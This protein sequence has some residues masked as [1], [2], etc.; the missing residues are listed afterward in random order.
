MSEST[1]TGIAT[2]EAQARADLAVNG[3]EEVIR[4]AHADV[5]ATTARTLREEEAARKGAVETRANSPEVYDLNNTAQFEI[6]GGFRNYDEYTDENI[7][8]PVSATDGKLNEILHNSKKWGETE[9]IRKDN[10]EDY[11]YEVMDL[12]DSGLELCQAKM[13]QD[14][15]ERDDFHASGHLIGSFISEG[16]EPNE[17][18]EKA[19]E[20]Y[21]KKDAARIKLIRENGLFTMQEYEDFRAQRTGADFHLAETAAALEPNPAI[22][23]P[24]PEVRPTEATLTAPDT[25]VT[26]PGSVLKNPGT[27][28]EDSTET[29]DGRRRRLR[30]EFAVGNAAIKLAE[31]YHGSL[32]SATAQAEYEAAK[33]R[34]V[35]GNDTY[36]EPGFDYPGFEAGRFDKLLK[37]IKR[38]Y[39]TR[40]TAPTPVSPALVAE[41]E[42]LGRQPREAESNETT[43]PITAERRPAL[44][45]RF[46]RRLKPS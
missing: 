19:D 42:A 38:N 32:P 43:A 16:L 3:A 28:A 22:S 21:A 23:P 6:Y 7:A 9:A 26:D 18:A 27:P 13:V 2:M 14:L 44:I 31:A 29:R 41:W 4:A 8:E 40:N 17:A 20:T 12:V 33:D 5:A 15:R 34:L 39:E 36:R 1:P 25:A 45:K 24:T 11:I 35:K 30:L 46:I 10:A 37:G